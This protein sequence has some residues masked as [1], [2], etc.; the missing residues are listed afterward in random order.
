MKSH[1]AFEKWKSETKT[2]EYKNYRKNYKMQQLKPQ[3]PL[4]VF[5]SLNNVFIYL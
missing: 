3:K 4:I 1:S 2:I 5:V